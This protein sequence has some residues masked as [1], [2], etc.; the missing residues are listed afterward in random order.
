M[1]DFK[2]HVMLCST[3]V[4]SDWASAMRLNLTRYLNCATQLIKCVP[5]ND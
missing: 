3:L 4:T 1:H 5:H 2:D